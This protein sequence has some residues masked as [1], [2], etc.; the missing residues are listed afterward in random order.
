VR[1]VPVQIKKRLR[2]WTIALSVD[3][4]ESNLQRYWDKWRW[5]WLHGAGSRD[6]MTVFG[7]LSS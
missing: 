2:H 6:L 7:H 5:R 4:V 1:I 3:L